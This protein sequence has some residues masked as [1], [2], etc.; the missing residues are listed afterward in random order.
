[1]SRKLALGVTVAACAILALGGPA[2]AATVVRIVLPGNVPTAVEV[3]GVQ[4]EGI[5]YDVTF[6]TKSTGAFAPQA[7]VPADETF[8]GDAAGALDASTQIVDALNVADVEEL[9]YLDIAAASMHT[10][11][12]FV[13]IDAA[14]PSCNPMTSPFFGDEGNRIS[15]SDPWIYQLDT[16]VSVVPPDVFAIFREVASDGNSSVPEPQTW[17]L[18]LLGFTSLGLAVRRK[19]AIA[20]V[21]AWKFR[22]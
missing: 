4:V 10:N 5:T 13:I 17:S 11:N 8:L 22:R 15:N 18:M 19:W 2:A 12:N 9:Q 20:R 6:A 1:M 21:R 14:C 7:T 3:D 16:G